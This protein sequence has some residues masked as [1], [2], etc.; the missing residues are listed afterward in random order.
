MSGGAVAKKR[1]K[2]GFALILVAAMAGLVFLLGA[3]L[4]ATAQLQTHA[5]QYDQ[6]MRQARENARA[7]LEMA[8][9]DLQRYAAKDG[10]ATYQSDALRANT[11]ENFNDEMDVALH[12]A[13]WTGAR[14]GTETRWLVTRPRVSDFNPD[15]VAVL[16]KPTIA[17]GAGDGFEEVTIVGRGT[18][19]P[20]DEADQL[21]YNVK[22]PKEKIRVFGVEGVPD[23]EGTVVGHYA[24]WVGETATKA[25][26]AL[27]DRTGEVKHGIY[28]DG[29]PDSENVIPDNQYRL[30]LRQLGLASFEI[31]VGEV[32]AEEES[33]LSVRMKGF[34]NDFQFRSEYGD[35]GS[36]F[37][38]LPGFS[39]EDGVQK[40]FHDFTPLSVGLL[41]NSLS[42]G[43]REDVGNYVENFAER[44]PGEYIDL[45]D[46]FVNNY[47]KG[48]INIPRY[49][50]GIVDNSQP[51][52]IYK[53]GG[54]VEEEGLTTRQ[55]ILPAL[56][57]F[58]INFTIHLS[59]DSDTS[60]VNKVHLTYD[61]GFELWNAFTRPLVAEGLQYRVR[62]LPKIG[63]W[64]EAKTGAPIWSAPLFETGSGPIFKL[65]KLVGDSGIW[66]AGQVFTFSGS[67][68]LNT[69]SA[70]VLGSNRASFSLNFGA[71]SIAM[72]AQL[73][74]D[75]L[76]EEDGSN[77][78][79]RLEID[80]FSEGVDVDA[81]AVPLA[82]YEFDFG[83]KA[84]TGEVDNPSMASAPDFGFGWRIADSALWGLVDEVEDED[85][86]DETPPASVIYDPRNT[87]ISVKALASDFSPDSNESSSPNLTKGF[88][89]GLIDILGH[90]KDDLEKDIPYVELPMQ[91]VTSIG[92]LAP[93]L[94]GGDASPRLGLA[95][96]GA[97][98]LYD[99]AFVSTIPYGDPAYRAEWV[100]T[101][102][103]PNTNYVLNAGVEATHDGDRN[104]A[105]KMLVRGMFN[106]N[107]TS[108]EA[109]RAILKANEISKYVD[110]V[111]AALEGT[112]LF[113]NRTQD[114]V[115][116]S[117]LDFNSNEHTDLEVKRYC[118]RQ[119][120]L[121]LT[122]VE[123]GD[124]ATNIVSRVRG[125]IKASGPF[126]SISEFLN[127]G[128][129][130]GAIADAGINPDWVV[131]GSPREFTQAT[132]M[133][134]I[135]PYASVRSDTFIVRAYGDSVDV[136][137]AT[138]V[139][140]RAYCEAV[141]RRVQAKHAS[142]T[143]Q[144]VMKSTSGVTE[145]EKS[146]F[147]RLFEVVAFRW[148]DGSEI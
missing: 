49:A 39:F 104:M 36:D 97:N 68:D 139:R 17:V 21:L 147:G 72:P 94:F 77:Q 44:A 53:M 133:N 129:L 59:V 10:V 118:F 107:S 111:P 88:Q 112:Y 62:G 7:A 122:N 119:S 37:S 141:V 28:A 14:I 132:I 73:F 102:I 9:G 100:K 110:S 135:G 6:A 91:E 117:T 142:E 83:F 67:S 76:D 80:V 123:V 106:L 70:D 137:D 86:E 81:D 146:Q 105:S 114:I 32:D 79:V 38:F 63:L 65:P 5:T 74:F 78:N 56:T 144:D 54:K 61:A 116:V 50:A 11:E 99:E 19:M 140:A 31:P 40:G 48:Y 87:V 103:L 3:S 24:Y 2:K 113:F 13:F 15:E 127:S 8:I 136:S 57:E 16:A 60:F 121:K 18:A 43:L 92:G 143:E 66:R 25:S 130:A 85:E 145:L 29:P 120:I 4:V 93:A 98:F 51:T 96:S 52:P 134:L 12:N 108:I 64:F 124:L 69:G 115:N 22:V 125:R 26:M 90:N 109:W 23:G 71:E 95:G 138:K 41:E 101:S 148:M 126:M 131:A 75:F 33:D 34:V 30:R 35:S 55:A 20:Q 58:N 42:G 89:D 45:L 27:Y 46:D 82:T 1:R 47:A 128:V 84:V